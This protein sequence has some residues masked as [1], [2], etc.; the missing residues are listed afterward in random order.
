MIFT[1]SIAAA[2]LVLAAP[3]VAQ[4]V[5][6][7]RGYANLITLNPPVTEADITDRPYRVIGRIE[8]VVRKVTIF[9]KNPSREKVFRELWERGRKM[10]ADA[11]IQARYVRQDFDAA[12]NPILEGTSRGE[13]ASGVAVKFLTDAEI[14]AMKPAS[15]RP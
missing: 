11:V 4:N 9:G 7:M 13:R 5:E 12:A 3:V 6:L 8:T 15:A 10:G 14:A 1:R 2:T